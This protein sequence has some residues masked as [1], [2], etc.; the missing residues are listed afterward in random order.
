MA[1]TKREKPRVAELTSAMR[2]L[3]V[4]AGTIRALIQQGKLRV[5]S[6]DTMG[7]A[8]AVYADDLEALVDELPPKVKPPVIEKFPFP[9]SEDWEV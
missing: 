7:G 8:T 4:P 5:G 3:K 9:G 2:Q 6:V 1:N